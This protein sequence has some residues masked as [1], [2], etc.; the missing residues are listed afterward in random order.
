[1]EIKKGRNIYKAGKLVKISLEYSDVIRKIQITGDFFLYPE[2]AIEKL[3]KSL[4]GAKLEKEDIKRRVNE[5]ISKNN[6][7]IFGFD[8]EQL[9]EAIL[10][11][12][13]EVKV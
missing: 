4:E 1:M 8:A 2:E 12:T 3:Q 13:Q 6:A 11:A 10:G 9:A 5:F 7:E